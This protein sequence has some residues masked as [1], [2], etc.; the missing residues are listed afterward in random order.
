MTTK[1]ISLVVDYVRKA[2][3]VLGTKVLKART[4]IG[5]SRIQPNQPR[6]RLLMEGRVK[7]E[8]NLGAV[9]PLCHN[10]IRTFGP[11]A[12]VSEAPDADPH[13]RWCWREAP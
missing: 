3:G 1:S 4:V 9:K 6:L 11:R 12:Q 7:P 5:S 8:G 10:V 2:E 13:V